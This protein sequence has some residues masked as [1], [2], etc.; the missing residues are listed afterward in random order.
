MSNLESMRAPNPE[1]HEPNKRRY[2]TKQYKI[3]ILNEIE[4]CTVPGGVGAI[5]RR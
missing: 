4:E 2:H 3:K 1:M 5:L